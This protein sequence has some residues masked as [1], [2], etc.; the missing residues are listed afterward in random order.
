MRKDIFL[1]VNGGFIRVVG[2]LVIV[3]F[4]FVFLY[5]SNQIYIILAIRK[6][7]LKSF[8]FLEVIYR[9]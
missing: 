6:Q 9:K 4:F 1:N 2:F 3:I 8:T 7:L 5:L